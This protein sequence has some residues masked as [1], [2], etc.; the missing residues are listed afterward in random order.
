MSK[1]VHKCLQV[2]RMTADKKT[3]AD[4]RARSTMIYKIYLEIVVDSVGH[5]WTLVYLYFT[6]GPVWRSWELYDRGKGEETAVV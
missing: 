2:S 3:N 5:L 4:F 1:S 6:F